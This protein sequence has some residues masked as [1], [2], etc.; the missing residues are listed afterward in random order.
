[1]IREILTAAVTMFT[2]ILI[3]MLA[4][5]A[6]GLAKA[7]KC[8][9]KI[10]SSKLRST[11]SKTIVYFIVLVIGGCLSTLGEESVAV[12]FAVFL[13]IVEGVSILENLGEMYPQH[14]FIAKLK[15]IL[16]KKQKENGDE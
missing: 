9:H 15:A 6:T 14:K 5:L 7:Y 16:N 11:V 13:G 4:D 1:M 10:S 3:L 8:Q 12:L 2:P